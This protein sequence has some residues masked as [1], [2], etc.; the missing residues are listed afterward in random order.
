MA[1]IN[2]HGLSAN[3]LRALKLRAFEHQR[4]PEDEVRD[5][6]EKLLCP[7]GR[8]QV[9][10]ALAKMSQASHLSNEDVNALEMEREL[11]SPPPMWFG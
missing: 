4:T 1:S 9:G 5:I 6:L 8:L 11:N 7:E 2:I 10:T 3:A